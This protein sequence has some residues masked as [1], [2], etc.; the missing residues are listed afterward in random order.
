MT[1]SSA[2]S[3]DVEAMNQKLYEELQRLGKG[4]ET[5]ANLA[6]NRMNVRIGQTPKEQIWALNKMRLFH[7]YPQTPPEQRKG[8][9]LLLVFALINRPDIFDLRPGNSFVE[10]MV[11]QGYDIYMLDWGRPGPEDKHYD[12]EDYSIKFLPRA[13]R[14][15]QRHSGSRE[16]SMCGWCIG[17]TITTIYAAMRPD[18]GLR[19]L[20]LL[21]APLDFADKEAG[22]YNK[23]L[24]TEFYNIDELVRQYDNV[25]GEIIDYGAKMLKPVENF[26]MNYLK[27]WDNLDNKAV[28]ESWLAMNTWVTDGVDFPG[29]AFRQWVVEFFRENRL[30]EATLMMEGRPV[31]MKNIKASVL[32]VIADKDHIVPNCQSTTAMDKIGSKDKLL[33]EMRGGHIGLMV[34]SGASKRTW[35][36]IDGWLAKRSESK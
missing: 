27:L 22:P 35:P 8:I 5:M 18:D 15:M 2:A 10:H 29:A 23:W 36:Q 31:D 3:F 19:N 25:P 11:R 9:P 14:A 32:N 20:I 6:A 30:M 16:F 24:N 34:G 12:F 1:T 7:F 4:T 17:A 33:L 21:T 28:V 26:V 13:V